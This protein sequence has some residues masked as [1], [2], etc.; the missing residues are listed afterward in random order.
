M[1]VSF[2]FPLVYLDAVA[3]PY[4]KAPVNLASL[5]PCPI[6]MRYDRSSP[7]RWSQCLHPLETELALWCHLPRELAGDVVNSRAED[8]R[9]SE[10]SALPSWSLTPCIETQAMLLRMTDYMQNLRGILRA[11]EDGDATGPW[12]LAEPVPQ[13]NHELDAATW[14]NP[15]NPKESREI[16]KCCCFKPS[17]FENCDHSCCNR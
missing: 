7:Q 16:T 13:P 17:H 4:N 11:H 1:A 6:A 3:D 2:P 8:L 12:V 9:I 15:V 14:V 5:C 10:P